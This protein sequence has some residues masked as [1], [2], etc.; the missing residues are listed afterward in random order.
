MLGRPT[1]CGVCY[2]L[3][4]RSPFIHPR[5]WHSMVCEECL[6]TCGI[7]GLGVPVWLLGYLPRRGVCVWFLVRYHRDSSAAVLGGGI[8]DLVIYPSSG[9]GPARVMPWSSVYLYARSSKAL[10]VSA[11]ITTSCGYA[12]L[13]RIYKTTM[14]GSRLSAMYITTGTTA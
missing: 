5:L 10:V 4:L 1:P 8:V 6:H 14:A 11:T 3:C 13:R 2:T 7:L 12:S 9:S